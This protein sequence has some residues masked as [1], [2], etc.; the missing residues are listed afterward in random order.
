MDNIN[1]H[2]TSP[3]Y[4]CECMIVL[5]RVCGKIFSQ[6]SL[7]ERSRIRGETV[8]VQKALFL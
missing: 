5:S 1:I 2:L 7:N 4:H 8:R 3:L 6:Q